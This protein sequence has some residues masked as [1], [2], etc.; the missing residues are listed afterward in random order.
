MFRRPCVIPCNCYYPTLQLLIHK[1]GVEYI[2]C[3]V[4]STKWP[5]V[6]SHA[7]FSISTVDT[8]STYIAVSHQFQSRAV[9]NR[10]YSFGCERLTRVGK[11]SERKERRT[12]SRNETKDAPNNHLPDDYDS[13]RLFQKQL[14]AWVLEQALS[15]Y[16]PW[17]NHSQLLR[18]V[19][20]R[21]NRGRT[22]HFMLPG[23]IKPQ[24]TTIF[25]SRK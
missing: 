18:R 16:L 5:T 1:N 13:L 6:S 11:F 22:L 2:T 3:I 4:A 21:K 14:V 23:H 10:G 9:F 25:N 24:V 7:N 15:F 20:K 17:T 19:V 8:R 12:L